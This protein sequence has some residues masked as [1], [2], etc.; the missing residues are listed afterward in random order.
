VLAAAQAIVPKVSGRLHASGTVETTD[1][2]TK[3]GFNTPYA[4]RVHELPGPGH[5]HLEKSMSEAASRLKAKVS[6]KAKL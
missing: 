4:A 5:K 6:S 2:G 3:V 1:D